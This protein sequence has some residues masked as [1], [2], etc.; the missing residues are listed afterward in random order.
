MLQFEKNN[1]MYDIL[2]DVC[3]YEQHFIDDMGHVI[4]TR[5]CVSGRGLL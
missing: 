4:K 3:G 5:L 2:Q 1:T